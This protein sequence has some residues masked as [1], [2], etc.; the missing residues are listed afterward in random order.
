MNILVTGANGFIGRA[1]T[2]SLTA[3]GHY[4][5]GLYSRA[6]PDGVNGS[7]CDLSDRSSV[8]VLLSNLGTKSWDAVVHLASVL[9][10]P[11]SDDREVLHTNLQM[12]WNVIELLKALQ[13]AT[14]LH[15]SSIAVYPNTSGTYD[16]SSSV[17]PSQNPEGVYGLSKV[18]AENLFDHQLRSHE[19]SICHLRLAQV[20]GVGMRK[21]RII[22][23]MRNEL[24]TTGKIRVFGRGERV[25]NF[26]HIDCLVDGLHGLLD[27]RIAPGI[28]NVG[29]ES[30]SYLDLARRIAEERGVG[31]EV[32]ELIE[33]GSRAVFKLDTS[34]YTA[35]L[36]ASCSKA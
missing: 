35:A 31:G 23:I 4:V 11:D 9:S 19:I 34:K 20:Y 6:V 10:H 3:S 8:E 30:L 13:P 17:Q 16:E 24:A 33:V 26:I 7:I 36:T 12:T 14:F 32:I 22:S 27:S 28:Y 2:E 18:C 5:V 25:S 15:A 1:L 29:D 21:D